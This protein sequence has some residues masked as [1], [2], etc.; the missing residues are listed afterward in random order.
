MAEC[1]TNLSVIGLDK[2]TCL[3]SMD[4]WLRVNPHKLWVELGGIPVIG[5]G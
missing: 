5:L 1:K 3:C 2:L 4:D